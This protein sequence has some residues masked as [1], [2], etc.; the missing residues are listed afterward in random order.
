VK[1][2]KHN[3]EK[4]PLNYVDPYKHARKGKEFLYDIVEKHVIDRKTRYGA[5]Q[6]QMM[7]SLSMN[8]EN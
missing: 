2:K 4:D 1:K 8:L 3:E 6:S 7:R 5:M